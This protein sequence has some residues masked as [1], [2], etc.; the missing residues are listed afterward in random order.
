M[1][2]TPV[3]GITTARGKVDGNP[4]IRLGEAYV[5]AVQKAG[6]LPLLLPVSE[7]AIEAVLPRLDGLVFSGG[8]DVN[9]QRFN[10]MPHPEVYGVDDLRDEMEI[11]LV[12]AAVRRGLPFLA[13]CRG[14]QVVNVALGGTLYTHISDQL[15]GALH[16]EYQDSRSRD[17]L[18]HPVDVVAGS[19]LAA[20][21]GSTHLMVNSMHHQGV[22]RVAPGLKPT[23]TAED[24][25]VEAL[26]LPDHPFG[27]AVQWHP[28]ALPKL[29]AMQAL[30]GGLIEAS[31]RPGA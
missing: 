11:N 15:P 4:T 17:Y 13:I 21:L 27:L 12:Q 26:E 6:G 24:S 31:R 25:L 16:H 5:N 22:Q 28:E 23:A 18:A 7:M 20:L 29:A 1:T 14:I 8:G 3:I 2:S 19:R 30:F 9:I 10:G